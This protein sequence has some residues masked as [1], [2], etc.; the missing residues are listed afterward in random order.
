MAKATTASLHSDQREYII[1]LYASLGAL[2]L[3]LTLTVAAVLFGLVQQIREATRSR[4]KL[5]RMA[6]ELRITADQAEAAN[7]TKSAFLATM[8]HEI[9]TPMNGVIGSVE[10]MLD[11]DLGAE[12][13]KLAG[14]I[15]TCGTTLIEFIDDILN[16]SKLEAGGIE[17]ENIAYDPVALI[18]AA[19]QMVEP[20]AAEKGLVII[21][22][23]ELASSQRFLGD[24]V[25][26]R[27]VIV[28][29][30]TNA[31]KFTEVGSVIVRCRHDAERG[32]LQIEVQDS[33]IGIDDEGKK[34]LF[35][36]FSQVDASITRRFGGSGL[37]L[38]I[39]QRIVER[40]GGL[41]GVDSKIGVGSTFWFEVPAELTEP[42]ELETPVGPT[43]CIDQV[44]SGEA[45]DIR[46]MLAYVG[47]TVTSSMDADYVVCVTTLASL[48][49][50]EVI[51]ARGIRR[52]TAVLAPESFTAFEY[53]A[54]ARVSTSDLGSLHV[55]VAED[56]RV[57]QE[58]AT[59]LLSRLGHNVTIAND[60]A[61]ALAL[62]TSHDYDVILMDMMMPVMDGLEA[63]SAIR[64]STGSSKD[65]P[66]LAVTA[67]A[68]ASDR[69]AC[70]AAGMNGF[71]TK[72]LGKVDLETALLSLVKGANRP[73]QEALP[74]RKDRLEQLID[75]LGSETV[76]FLLT[77]FLEDAA[78]LAASIKAA[79]ELGDARSLRDALHT[80]KGAAANVG[81]RDIEKIA[82]ELMAA[83]TPNAAMLSR[84]MLA[85]ETAENGAFATRLK[86]AAAA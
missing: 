14:T 55:L 67:N 1:Q 31:V 65:I 85:I 28:N 3:A 41:I 40:M 50:F 8:S 23:P 56:N 69:E 83:C 71:V 22:A 47:A 12:A 43:V 66:I 44:S 60:G 49:Q 63:T 81:F 82:I 7:R 53:A 73:V 11:M 9:R 18:G 15:R 52:R 80:L 35:K 4:F 76:D 29:L 33:G 16:F 37:G 57:N 36:E 25:R 10:I 61:Q 30:V 6:A 26:L 39:S 54:T 17:L 5:E 59:V 86:I 74:T 2:V 75:E 42:A 58:V 78:H 20:R 48:K 24:P 77:C 19:V 46:T 79:V 27:Q 62:A 21:V 68:F 32:R 34:R 84:L 13:R 45:S 51:T 64:R 38:A 70:L 72:P